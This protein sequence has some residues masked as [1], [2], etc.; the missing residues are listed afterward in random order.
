MLDSGVKVISLRSSECNQEFP[1]QLCLWRQATLAVAVCDGA[2]SYGAE[3]REHERWNSQQL[4]VGLAVAECQG[5]G[6][7]EISHALGDDTHT[8]GDDG[9][10]EE[11]RLLQ[12]SDGVTQRDSTTFGCFH[13]CGNP[14]DVVFLLRCGE[15]DAVWRRVRHGPESKG[16]KND[17]ETS[18]E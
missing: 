12:T 4:E 6:G 1:W 14:L 18:L 2:C 9:S 3:E 13:V 17:G 7:C 11:M 10:D 16:T 15:R 5:H 8:K